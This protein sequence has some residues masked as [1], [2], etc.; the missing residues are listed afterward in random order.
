MVELA[1]NEVS[2]D[3][4]AGRCH[5][6]RLVIEAVSFG[7]AVDEHLLQ[8]FAVFGIEAVI[9]V[10]IVDLGDDRLEVAVTA[11]FFEDLTRDIDRAH[12][13]DALFL[14]VGRVEVEARHHQRFALHR[15]QQTGEHVE[16]ARR[17]RSVGLDRDRHVDCMAD[18]RSL[19]AHELAPT[20]LHRAQ[21]DRLAAVD[22]HFRRIDIGKSRGKA[23]EDLF[24]AVVGFFEH[25]SFCRI[26]NCKTV[27]LGCNR[28]DRAMHQRQVNTVAD[29]ARAQFE[30]DQVHAVVKFHRNGMAHVGH[31]F[32]TAKR[33]I[34]D[35]AAIEENAAARIFPAKDR[36][37]FAFAA[38]VERGIEDAVALFGHVE[39]F[40][41]GR[42][43]VVRVKPQDV[44]LVH[45]FCPNGRVTAEVAVFAAQTEKRR[46]VCF[47]AKVFKIVDCKDL[48][49][50]IE[51]FGFKRTFRVHDKRSRDHKVHIAEG[52]RAARCRSFFQIFKR[53]TGDIAGD[54]FFIK[55]CHCVILL[56]YPITFN[57]RLYAS[58]VP[59]HAQR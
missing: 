10:E 39:R 37:L 22:R 3:T 2:D 38:D 11:H 18:R 45:A 27:T 23:G 28:I 26:G 19:C 49:A 17:L 16:A 5:F 36:T 14:M 44:P 52:F 56:F 55:L 24:I 31:T 1:V 59:R 4:F 15:R 58:F 33:L 53:N 41:A 20:R 13:V 29:V 9:G 54:S 8:E 57:K 32:H 47:A 35:H 40:V 30:E 43:A 6:V 50:F 12:R 42:V 25:G 7:V 48:I 51:I 46:D 21:R 34:S